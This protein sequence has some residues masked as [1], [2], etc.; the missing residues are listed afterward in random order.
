MLFY[1][2]QSF[3][4]PHVPYGPPYY[5]NKVIVDILRSQ[6]GIFMSLSTLKRRLQDYGLKRRGVDIDENRLRELIQSEIS[7]PG[8]L[9]GYR[10]F[11][12][13]LRLCHKVHVA[14]RDVA[15]ILRARPRRNIATKKQKA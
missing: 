11:W 13:S 14:R 7:G 6:H 3:K 4:I 9:R 8:Q 15:R 5:E 10:D 12:H 2:L 1:L